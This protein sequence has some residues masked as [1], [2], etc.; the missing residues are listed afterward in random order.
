MRVITGMKARVIACAPAVPVTT[1][2]I[3]RSSLLRMLVCSSA[4]RRS[5]TGDEPRRMLD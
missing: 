2:K 5:L 1:V 4:A 3:L